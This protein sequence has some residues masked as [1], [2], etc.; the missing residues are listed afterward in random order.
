MN[1]IAKQNKGFEKIRHHDEDGNE[2][3]Y[4]RE[5]AEILEY[6]QWR[7]FLLVLDKA[8]EACENSG[9]KAEYHFADVS[10]M[11]ELGKGAQRSVDDCRL[12][13][14]AC[15]LIETFNIHIESIK[16]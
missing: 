5:L 4:A 9:Q 14:Y 11:V 12:S 15:Y 3:W 16:N 8:K 13:R 2:F 10:K 1:E 6:A 7:N